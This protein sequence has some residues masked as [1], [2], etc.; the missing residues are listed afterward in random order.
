MRDFDDLNVCNQL[1]F[2]G[3]DYY[4]LVCNCNVVQKPK[5]L[6]TIDGELG[7]GF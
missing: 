6:E 7:A 5:E 4:L 1:S 3:N 2:A